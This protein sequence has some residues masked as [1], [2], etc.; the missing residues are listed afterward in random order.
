MIAKIEGTVVSILPDGKT[1]SGKTYRGIQLLQ[2]GDKS[3]SLVRVRLWNGTKVELGK[4]LAVTAV[5]DA[6]AGQ[7]GGAF[8]SVDVF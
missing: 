7:R 8:L 3:A 4:P 6:F 2:Q 1:K 5:V